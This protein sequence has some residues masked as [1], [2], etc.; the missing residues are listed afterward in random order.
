VVEGSDGE[1]MSLKEANRSSSNVVCNYSQSQ[2]LAT[3]SL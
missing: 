2:D 1:K 3:K